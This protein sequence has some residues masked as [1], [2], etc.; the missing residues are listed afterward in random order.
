MKVVVRAVFTIFAV[1]S[2][3]AF[4]QIASSEAGACNTKTAQLLV[5]QQVA[6][7][8][9][10]TARPK[11]IKILLRSADFLWPLDQP[12]ARGYFVEAYK[13]AGEHF[14]EKGF[15]TANLARSGS[16]GSVF[17]QM[18]DLRTEVI[19]AVA[20]R[21]P[22]LAKKFTDQILAEYEKAAKDRNENDKTR[23]QADLL[24]MAADS[25]D[26]NPEFSRYLFRRLMTYPL[27]QNWFWTLYSTARKNQ[28]L[29]DSI[30]AEALQNFRN[31]TPNHLLY[32]SAYPFGNTKMFGQDGSRY[33]A[34]EQTGFVPDPSLQRAFLDTFFSRIIAFAANPDDINQVP[35]KYYSPEA[36]NMVT[37]LNDIEPIIIE[38]FPAML[39]RFTVAR[40]AA[41]SLLTAEM[42]K[43]IASKEKFA[44]QNSA[45]F[46]ERI[47]ELEEAEGK[48][49]LTDSMIARIVYPGVI[50][51]DEQYEIYLSW[52]P[53]IRDEKVRNEV[54]NYFWYLRSQLA[55]KE[56]R[57]DD[58]E[59]MAQKVP[60]ID[61]RAVVMFDIAKK[62]LDSI[63]DSGAAFGTLNNVSKVARS[64]PN[65]VA[66][67]QVLLSLV[68]FYERI[69]H[70]VALDE[71]SES[72][73]V[74]NQL[75]DPDLFQNWIFRQIVGKDFAFMTSI[76]LPGSNFEGIFTDIGKKDFEM[77]LANAR[78]FDDKY[79]KTIAVLAIA[80]NCIQPK[81][82][83][84]KPKAP[85][86][87]P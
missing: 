14:T 39:Q 17:T 1:G 22:E 58:A 54:M 78:G 16:G 15:E 68:Q 55:I 34:N 74:V 27:I 4:A 36:V 48:G 49:K 18:P 23:E 31:E 46:E 26:T 33:I 6:E 32:L 24:N 20:K 63:N 62:Q 40:S 11:R 75:D 64:A 5:E 61:H 65:S 2:F 87:K 28:S 44:S 12:T 3:S 50:R 41:N 56:D 19:K 83:P 67:A 59:R 73:R 72:V 60:E 30:Y 43:D 84:A 57:L 7:S 10:V 53:K 80:K 9:S 79:F 38:R 47:A 66:K 77:A 82:P 81:A 51:K 25:A 35:E 71:L 42:R 37:A 69:N 13:T 45:T 76:S 21:D 29:A 86:A 70:S 85:A 52:I 8:K